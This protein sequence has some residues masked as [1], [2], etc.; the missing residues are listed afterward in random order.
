LLLGAALGRDFSLHDGLSFC[1]AVRGTGRRHMP[2]LPDG[3][4][5]LR[6][7]YRW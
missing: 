7:G 6:L 3:A 2:D 4:L 5:D 1:V